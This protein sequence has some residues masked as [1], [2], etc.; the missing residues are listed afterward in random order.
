MVFRRSE[1]VI[2]SLI[3]LVIFNGAR[4]II[5]DARGELRQSKFRRIIIAVPVP[6]LSAIGFPEDVEN[7]LKLGFDDYNITKPF[8]LEALHVSLRKYI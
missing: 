4:Y 2:G 6:G 7:A 3:V 5:I 8:S 1:L